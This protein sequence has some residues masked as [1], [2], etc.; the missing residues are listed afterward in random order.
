MSKTLYDSHL[1]D[2]F[3]KKDEGAAYGASGDYRQAEFKRNIRCF[4]SVSL[5]NQDEI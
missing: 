4:Q 1:E 3:E 5:A 2:N